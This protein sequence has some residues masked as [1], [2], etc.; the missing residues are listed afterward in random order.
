[1]FAEAV[2]A[3]LGVNV[4][5]SL[6]VLPAL[7]VGADRSTI[8]LLLA[9]LPLGILA[10]GLWR[11][12]ELALLL[13]FPSALLLPVALAPELVSAHVYGAVRFAV[14]GVGLVAYL[15]GV[16]FFMS[17]YEPP[18]PE[19]VRPLAPLEQSTPDRW[20]RR[21][22][23]YRYLTVLA[24]AMPLVLLYA[25]N[26]DQG[27]RDALRAMYPGRVAAM[28]TVLNLAV[29][30]VWVLLF[31]HAL[32]G[33]LRAHRAGDRDLFRVLARRGRGVRSTRPRA[34]F[35]IG[36]AGAVGLM[37]LLIVTRYL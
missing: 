29:M 18:T 31:S 5:V 24:A 30:G 25:V 12:S 28:T 10:I 32:L 3:A 7:F 11:S 36:V 20:R 4:W 17:W 35:Y 33:V 21:F 27:N 23:V 2:A 34:S 15:L 13:G 19:R 8:F 26:Y 37:L 22:R 9:A 1:M 14:V 16:S 6:V